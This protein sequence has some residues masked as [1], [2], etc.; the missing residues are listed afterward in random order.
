MVSQFGTCYAGLC[1]TTIASFALFGICRLTLVNNC[2]KYGYVLRCFQHLLITL[3]I[4]MWL[5]FQYVPT[6]ERGVLMCSCLNQ[7]VS[8]NSKYTYKK[9]KKLEGHYCLVGEA[10]FFPLASS[11]QVAHPVGRLCI[12]FK[13]NLHTCLI[14][15]QIWAL[16]SEYFSFQSHYFWFL[17]RTDNFRWTNFF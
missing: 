13:Q 9:C 3:F 2:V 6:L 17:P 5:V 7:Y 4:A 11:N 16:N 12:W 1:I 14:R 10:T 8:G 15:P